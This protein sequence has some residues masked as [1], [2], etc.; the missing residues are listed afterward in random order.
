MMMTMTMEFGQG[1]PFRRSDDMEFLEEISPT[2]I[3]LSG[4]VA[5]TTHLQLLGTCGKKC[6][7]DF[8]ATAHQIRVS[9]MDREVFFMREVWYRTFSKVPF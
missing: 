2:G 3:S 9:T 6:H 7:I 4:T 5:K 1:C 8:P